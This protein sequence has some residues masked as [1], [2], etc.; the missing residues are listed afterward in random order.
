MDV[1]DSPSPA[2]HPRVGVVVP[3]YRHSI[4]RRNRLKRRLRE[5]LRQDVLTRLRDEEQPVDLL[6]RARP[7][8]YDVDY[9]VLRDELLE[10]LERRWP[11][12]S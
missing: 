2:P 5:I 3:R 8:A 7:E 11:Q 1:I 10:V 6:V 9:T 12:S 4:V